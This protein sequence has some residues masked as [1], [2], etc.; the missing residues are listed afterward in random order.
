MSAVF[1]KILDMGY[2]AGFPFVAVLLAWLLLKK[3]PKRMIC[4]LWLLV[5]VRLVCPFSVKSIFSLI[6]DS[7]PL[8]ETVVRE[9]DLPSQP[10]PQNQGMVVMDISGHQESF[11]E[12]APEPNKYGVVDILA[13]VWA[14]GAVLMLVYSIIGYCRLKKRTDVS[15]PVR[16][17]IMKCDAVDTP[18]IL[19]VLRPRIFLPSIM[20]DS[21]MEYVV[22]HERAHIK[23]HDHWW[24]PLGFL[25]LCVYWFYPHCWYSYIQFCRDIEQAC[26]EAVIKTMGIEDKKAYAGALLS[27]SMDRRQIAAY[28]LA[29]GEVGVKE[30]IKNILNYKK[31]TF[32]VIAASVAVGI[33][34]AVC[35]LTDPAETKIGEEDS[36]AAFPED[37]LSEDGFSEGY[38]DEELCRMA[39]DYY[40]LHSDSGDIPVHVDV[41]SVLEDGM[42]LIHL[43]DVVYDANGVGWTTSKEWYTVDRLTGKGYDFSYKDIDLTEVLENGNMPDNEEWL[44]KMIDRWAQAFV[45]RDGETIASLASSEVR[46][47]LSRAELLTGVEGEYGFGMSSPW[48]RDADTDYTVHIYNDMGMAEIWYYAYTSDPHVFVWRETLTYAREGDAYVVT[49][50][51]LVYYHDI[52][53]A[54][55]Y[56][57]AYPMGIDATMMDYTRNGLG[58]ALNEKAASDTDAY[59]DLLSP[60]SAAVSLL[61]LSADDVSISIY[62]GS[63]E[64]GM[65]GLDILFLK[66]QYIATISMVQPYGK[67]GIWVPTDYQLDVMSRFLRVPWDEVEAIPE[68]GYYD[69]A[70]YENIICIGEIPEYDIRVYGYNDEDISGRGVAI[71]IGDD[72]NYFDWFYTSSIGIMPNLYWDEDK[73]QL[74]ITFHT[75]TGTGFSG[76]ELVILEQYD[77]GTLVPYYFGYQD[78]PEML[79]E[80][81]GY[82]IDSGSQRITLTDTVTGREIATVAVPEESGRITGLE[83]GNINYFELGEPVRFFV[84]TGFFRDGYA[85]AEYEGMPILEFEIEYDPSADAFVLGELMEVHPYEE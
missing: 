34:A 17:N 54:A 13:A 4:L 47:G 55:E 56:M 78:Y 9:I 12:T 10:L 60:V 3:A 76:E 2:A 64:T 35:F 8:S 57:E 1:L 72:V 40:I 63:E 66:D 65:I 23:R 24:K 19:G 7:A 39:Y 22:A 68:V 52:S 70:C 84:E 45:N 71:Q 51:E 30:R 58:E 42:V 48:P 21:E 32:W 53:S 83:S 80:R 62:D 11:K 67:N 49:G 16:E 31:P 61:N 69:L 28:P 73:R 74:Q 50:E 15:I 37:G 77:T 18:F 46:D 36:A 79:S 38:T 41:D 82:E 27:Y 85:V 20:D 26:D 29:F 44:G 81:I 6:P 43:Y 5:A 25:I 33:A 59:R 14:A 75:L